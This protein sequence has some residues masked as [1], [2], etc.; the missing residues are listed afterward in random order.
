MNEIT[1][2][3]LE[4]YLKI[5]E[6]LRLKKYDYLLFR[7]QSD[8]NSL[9]PG[10]ARKNQDENILKKE[11]EMLDH[12]KRVGYMK[13]KDSNDDWETLIIAQHNKMLTRLLDWSSNPLV[14]LWFAIEKEY[15]YNQDSYVYILASNSD[16]AISKHDEKDPFSLKEIKILKP[17]LNNKRIIAQFGWFTIHNYSLKNK[18]F[19]ALDED[20]IISKKLT[21]ITI[22]S[23]LKLDLLNKLTLMGVNA[24]SI[25]P[26]LEGYCRHI[27]WK[28]IE[29]E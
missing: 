1:L 7:G 25:F 29:R 10:I 19:I 20:P 24:K 27:N 4:D 13:L 28:Y 8:N 3:G 18:K 21:K 14:A 22:P 12:L 9:L 15:K 2:K 16:M 11:K 6:P 23:D 26:D 5:I 17:T